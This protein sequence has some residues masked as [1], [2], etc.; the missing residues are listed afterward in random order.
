MLLLLEVFV[1]TD[2]GLRLLSSLGRG[3]GWEAGL[4]HPG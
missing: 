4:T 2:G 1:S 3:R